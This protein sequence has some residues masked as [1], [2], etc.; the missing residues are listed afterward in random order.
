MSNDEK[1]RIA[2]ETLDRLNQS[3][4][5]HS[6]ALVVT[7]RG[8]VDPETAYIELVRSIVALAK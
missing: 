2:L 5:S 6:N 3:L 8:A 7:E 1:T 4:T